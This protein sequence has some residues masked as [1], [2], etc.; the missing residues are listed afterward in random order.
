MQHLEG[1]Q[2]MRESASIDVNDQSRE[3]FGAPGHRGVPLISAWG[4]HIGLSY[5]R[6]NW[7]QASLAEIIHE[8]VDRFVKWGANL[9]DLFPSNKEAH[10]DEFSVFEDAALPEHTFREHPDADQENRWTLREFLEFNRHAHQ[11]DFLVTWMIH[12][13]WPTPVAL[14]ARS[15][16]RLFRQV[17][18]DVADVALDGFGSHI[19]GYVAEG[20]CLMPAAANNILWQYHPGIYLRESAWGLNTTTA[21]YIQ[22]RGF[23]L[24]DGRMLM[25]DNDDYIGLSPECW[26]GYE[27]IWRG[28]ELRLRHG[29]LFVSLQAEGRDTKCQ[30]PSWA[31]FGGMATRDMML[32]QVNN[33]ARAKGRGW[34]TAGT[35]EIRVINETLISPKMKRF[36]GGLCSDPVRAAVTA[37]LEGTAKDGRYPR[38]DYPQ[39]AWFCQNNRFRIYLDKQ[40]GVVDL[41][42]DSSAQ[43]NFT[44]FIWKT[45][46][47]V[48]NNWL[49]VEPFGPNTQ[50]HFVEYVAREE[51][52]CLAKVRQRLEYRSGAESMGEHRDFM[53][54]AD[55]PWLWVRI[56]RV[57]LGEAPC[58][59]AVSVLRLPGY[60]PLD[61]VQI[62][63]AMRLA[64]PEGKPALWVYLPPT[65]QIETVRWCDEGR[66]EIACKAA[67][68]HDFRIGLCVDAPDQP[69]RELRN[70][71][72]RFYAQELELDW[73]NRTAD[74]MT[75]ENPT[76]EE[77]VRAVRI[78][79]PAA[80]AYVVREDGWW[81]PRGAQPS[82]EQRGTDLVKVLIG[83]NG[84]SAIAAS[85]FI[86]ELVKNG[87]GC[88]YT[89]LIR[90]VEAM[91]DGAG[92]TVRV[93]D[94]GPTVWAPRLHFVRQIAAVE[95][96]G[97][98]WHYF[99]GPFV[100]LP[101]ARGDYR[102]RVQFGPATGPHLACTF[103]TVTSTEWDGNTLSVTASLPEWCDSL[104]DAEQY[105]L[106]VRN[107]RRPLVEAVGGRVA[108][109]VPDFDVVKPM[110]MCGP[111]GVAKMVPRD[112]NHPP[113]DGYKMDKS[114]VVAF[115]P[116]T[117]L[118]LR[119]R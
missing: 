61:P 100:M 73:Q 39:G 64:P 13:W 90:D 22:P 117:H 8:G 87:W 42:Y 83:P 18:E 14:R 36:I 3:N 75:V 84:S 54:E 104:A 116:P 5:Q 118:K 38:V 33:Y 2:V 68:S 60:R 31:N 114:Q 49:E 79:H 101:N 27:T 98:P 15:L 96:D 12:C 80:G 46:T 76:S 19:D 7:K 78:L 115:R 62:G 91:P 35:T 72:A 26:R 17:G 81:Q 107:E 34:T 20:D 30:D 77:V 37:P 110:P 97:K 92:L 65:E 40:T 74:E 4:I 29:R 51:A 32:E 95:L 44:N 24:T 69:D 23:H 45:S 43:A 102:I 88:Q 82:W 59:R 56:Q 93:V 108:R 9:V 99:D 89:Q 105:F 48:L 57:F 10:F 63:E 47:P 55:N 52:G 71:A 113:L 58:R 6:P 1:N 16:W 109:S 28:E 86:Q 41:H 85:G 25:Y 66:L 112:Y 50:L 103:A 53:A 67:E 94:V 70:A 106:A 11:N 111:E 119:F 21:N